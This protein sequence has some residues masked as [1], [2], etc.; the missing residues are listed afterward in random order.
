[1][2]S[3]QD[4]QEQLDRVHALRAQVAKQLS[5]NLV[6]NPALAEELNQQIDELVEA[7]TIADLNG[8]R[9]PDSGLGELVLQG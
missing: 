3:E 8:P 6:S 1:M 9:P 4:Y 5:G 7:V 2:Q